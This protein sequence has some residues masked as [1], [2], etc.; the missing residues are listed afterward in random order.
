MSH[1]SSKALL[2]QG[3]GVSWSWGMLRAVSRG[4]VVLSSYFGTHHKERLH[5]KRLWTVSVGP[6]AMS[7]GNMQDCEIRGLGFQQDCKGDWIW[8]QEKS[9]H[10][11]A[12][13]GSSMGMSLATVA[14]TISYKL[15]HNVDWPA[16]TS[17]F[18]P[19]GGG[20]EVCV[21]RVI[22]LRQTKSI[23]YLNQS[24]PNIPR[25]WQRKPQKLKCFSWHL[26]HRFY[27]T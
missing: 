20:E 7:R 18:S 2:A 26:P 12:R 13:S 22:H 8:C 6:R 27:W 23:L 19:S 5:L 21:K 17:R 11:V 3:C 9:T 4:N 1:L 10:R 25:K 24:F 16:T 15:P 14:N